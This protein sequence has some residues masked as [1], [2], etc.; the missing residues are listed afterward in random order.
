MSSGQH[1]RDCELLQFFSVLIG[2]TLDMNP[3]QSVRRVF[4]LQII[5]FV[6][7]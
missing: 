2:D 7:L 3:N 5:K 1:D 4:E 6:H